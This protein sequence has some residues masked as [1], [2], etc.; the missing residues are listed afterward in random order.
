MQKWYSKGSK[1]SM[2]E[3]NYSVQFTNVAMN[4]L[5]EIYRYISEKLFAEYAA[6]DLL[7]QIESSIMRLGVFPNSGSR[8]LDGY[9]RL[10]GYRRIIVGSYIIFYIADEQLREVIIMRILYGKRKYED[11][12]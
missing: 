10:K 2:V 7:I 6:T 9:L 12:L 5:D 11:L 8:V 3:I 1:R 4:D